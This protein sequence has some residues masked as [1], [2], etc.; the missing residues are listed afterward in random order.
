MDDPLHHSLRQAMSGR[1]R[2][3]DTL[4]AALATRHR[5]AAK[6]VSRAGAAIAQALET[7]PNPADGS[8]RRVVITVKPIADEPG[9]YAFTDSET[10][11]V[12]GT[13][14]NLISVAKQIAF[15]VRTR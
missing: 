12:F 13:S 6:R 7:V 4:A 8:Q 2:A 9:T 15:A 14:S 11:R 3:I 5:V 10:G 1:A